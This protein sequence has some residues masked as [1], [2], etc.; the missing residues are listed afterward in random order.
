MADGAVEG[1]GEG[2]LHEEDIAERDRAL[3]SSARTRPKDGRAPPSVDND[4]EPGAGGRRV[5]AIQ[6]EYRP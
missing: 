2:S 6:L 5:T 4:A 1:E 3:L